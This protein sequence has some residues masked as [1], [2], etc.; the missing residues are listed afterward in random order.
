MFFLGY[1]VTNR[2]IRALTFFIIML[3]NRI[4]IC[5]LFIDSIWLLMTTIPTGIFLLLFSYFYR[6]TL[7]SNIIFKYEVFLICIIVF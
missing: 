3:F 1:G 6:N 5:L 7:V 4:I 2:N